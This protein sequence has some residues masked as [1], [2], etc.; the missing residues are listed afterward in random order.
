LMAVIQST[1]VL[2]TD[3]YLQDDLD[4]RY[5]KAEAN[6]VTSEE[7]LVHNESSSAHSNRF[8]TLETQVTKINPATIGNSKYYGTNSG[9]TSGYYDFPAA[10][11]DL[12]KIETITR[13]N[14]ASTLTFSTG[15]STDYNS[16]KVVALFGCSDADTLL[17]FNG[18]TGNNYSNNGV[19]TS[20]STVGASI[21]T[22]EAQMKIGK[23]SREYNAIEITISNITTTYHGVLF[24]AIGVDS[25]TGAGYSTT[26]GGVWKSTN[27]IS[28]ITIFN[29]GANF[30]GTFTLYGIK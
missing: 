1:N 3:G 14:D 27:A 28:S 25:G 12:V 6:A 2:T 15:F 10:S 19:Y 5:T 8:D 30:T 9:G 7:V 26:G 18:D 13:T 11:Q 23:D 22:N 24:N 4:D 29:G 16:Y 17:R 21:N 20:G